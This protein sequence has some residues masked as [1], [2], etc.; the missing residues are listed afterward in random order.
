MHETE[1]I[2]NF[3]KLTQSQQNRIQREIIDFCNLNDC[4]DDNRLYPVSYT[5]LDVYKRQAFIRDDHGQKYVMKDVDGKLVKIYI[6]TGKVYFNMSTEV[7][8]GLS[9]TDYIAFPYGDGAIEGTRTQI[10]MGDNAM[11]GGY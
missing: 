1:L 4:L 3:N 5:H 8:S 2:T 6:K 9:D 10:G 7:L 11:Y